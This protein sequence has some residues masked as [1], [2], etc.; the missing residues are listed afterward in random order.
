MGGDCQ[1]AEG[2]GQGE[3]EG[4]GQKSGSDWGKGHTWNETEGRP[5]DGFHHDSWRDSER[6]PEQLEDEFQ[7]LYDPERLRDAESL[8]T[9][10]E[11][12][13]DMEGHID[14]LPVR[15]LPGD[16]EQVAVPS[17][18]MPEGYRKAAADALG[19]ETIPPG[20]REQVKVYFDS[21]EGE[22]TQNTPE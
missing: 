6:T 3:G 12:Q 16:G 22:G 21:V 19:D 17:I 11:G 2:Q 9:S 13:L 18:D 20:Y 8:L 14:T 10:A 7:D 5:E 4:D 15:L 1:L